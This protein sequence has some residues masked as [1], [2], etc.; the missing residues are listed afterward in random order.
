MLSLVVVKSFMA[1]LL[2]NDNIQGH[3]RRHHGDLLASL[4][5]TMDAIAADNRI[6]EQE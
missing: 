3:L 6:T 4:V 1:R 2:R 5:S